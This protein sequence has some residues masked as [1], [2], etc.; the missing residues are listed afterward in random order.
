MKAASFYA[1]AK[2]RVIA[3]G[4]SEEIEWQASQNPRNVCEAQFI[5]EAAWVI[6]CSGFKEEIVRKKFNYLSLCFCEWA[7]AKLIVENSNQ[8]LLTAMHALAYRQKHEAIISISRAIEVEGFEGFWD[9]ISTDPVK[10][11]QELPYIG[12]ITSIHLAKNL[13][14]DLAKP[15]R[16][17]LRL[18]ERLGYHSVEEMCGVIAKDSGDPV[19]VVDLV[20]WRFLERR[21]I[22]EVI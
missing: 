2:D 5:R 21:Q 6:Y 17:L 12:P 3:L 13:G 14:F 8:C 7:S 22:L 9:E 20:L 18:K 1:T 15:D 16:H 10:N 19:R 4:Y 11:L